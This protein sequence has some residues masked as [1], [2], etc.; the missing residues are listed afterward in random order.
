MSL[1]S[2]STN[3]I[4]CVMK[5]AEMDVFA[6]FGLNSGYHFSELQKHIKPSIYSLRRKQ[7]RAERWHKGRLGWRD[8]SN[9]LCFPAQKDA[10]WYSFS[11]WFH[12]WPLCCCVMGFSHNDKVELYDPAIVKVS[13]FLII[14]CRRKSQEKFSFAITQRVK[15]RVLHRPWVIGVSWQSRKKIDY[16]LHVITSVFAH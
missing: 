11:F 10:L 8:A 6:T 4:L 16:S 13:S 1:N 2:F 7:L 3:V 5:T 12:R 15:T 14:A 9:K